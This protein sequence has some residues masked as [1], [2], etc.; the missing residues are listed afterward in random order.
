[1]SFLS[2]CHD[3]SWN[4]LL[5]THTKHTALCWQVWTADVLAMYY[6]HELQNAIGR[7]IPF[8]FLSL[9]CK[10][11]ILPRSVRFHSLLACTNSLIN[12][13]WAN[14]IFAELSVYPKSVVTKSKIWGSWG[15][16]HRSALSCVIDL[17]C[18]FHSYQG[19]Y[20]FSFGNWCCSRYLPRSVDRWTLGLWVR[21]S[22]GPPTR[23][24]K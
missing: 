20:Q 21:I 13:S 14:K 8:L 16:F 1:M 17:R 7:V 4:E 12:I 6:S 15:G 19:D 22:V 2:D 5:W 11:Y 24:L 23:V 10:P 3:F 9:L 18:S